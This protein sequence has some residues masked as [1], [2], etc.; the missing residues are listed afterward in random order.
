ALLPTSVIPLAEVENDHRMFFPFVGLALAVSWCSA[1]FV[2]KQA[3]R[4]SL[5]S[6]GRALITRCALCLLVG[7][8]YGAHL[9]NEV[10]HSEESLWQDVT[11]KSPHNG[12]GLMNY[13]LTQMSKGNSTAAYD[14]FQR[15]ALYTP[16]YS[17]LE[18]NLGLAA[19]ELS[20]D[21]EA[22]QHFRR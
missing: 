13:G 16:N 12:R 7:S 3:Q 4:M 2:E 20:R 6:G 17:L 9:R 5:G 10:W 8:G 11:L 1:L 14:Y 19:G 22:E 18:V 21:A 15:A